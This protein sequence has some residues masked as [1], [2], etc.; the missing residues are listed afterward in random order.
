MEE[1]WG[2]AH[3]PI[4]QDLVPEILRRK[5]WKVL[6]A[7]P[8]VFDGEMDLVVAVEAE[9]RVF[10]LATEVKGRVWSRTPTDQVLAKARQ[11]AFVGAVRREGSRSRSCRWCSDR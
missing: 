9:G 4:A 10:T 2:L 5:G 8:L 6:K 7:T 3:E 1:R 11:P